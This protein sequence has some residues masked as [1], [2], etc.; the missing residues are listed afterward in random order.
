MSPSVVFLL[1][2]A[3][4]ESHYEETPDKPKLKN[5]LQNNWPIPLKKC[6]GQ[7]III[8]MKVEKMVTN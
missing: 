8:I 4:S 2:N 7:K 3:P 6:Q 5:I 1:K